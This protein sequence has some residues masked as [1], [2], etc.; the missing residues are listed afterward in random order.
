DE[1]IS[2][3]A[4]AVWVIL[5]EDIL[6]ELTHLAR[7]G[8]WI[9]RPEIIAR[10]FGRARNFS[11]DAEHGAHDRLCPA[12]YSAF[13]KRLHHAKTW[14]RLDVP[15]E[16]RRSARTHKPAARGAMGVRGWPA[17]RTRIGSSNRNSFA[18]AVFYWPRAAPQQ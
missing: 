8:V 11:P 7:F 3:A 9:L 14:R 12:R 5:L 13:I 1:L 2:D 16:K 4:Y 6:D 10:K 15:D 18:L 17:A